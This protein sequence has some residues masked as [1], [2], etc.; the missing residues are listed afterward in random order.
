MHPS[1]RRPMLV[2]QIVFEDGTQWFADST[3]NVKSAQLAEVG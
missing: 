2:R 1:S 3:K